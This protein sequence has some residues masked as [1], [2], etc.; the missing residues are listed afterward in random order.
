MHGLKCRSLLGKLS[1]QT[2]AHRHT[3]T[4]TSAK[5]YT[6]RHTYTRTPCGRHS[7]DV[8]V[9][10]HW[11]HR[12][13]NQPSDFIRLTGLTVRSN[14]DDHFT[15]VSHNPI[16]NESK[17][18]TLPKIGHT[19]IGSCRTKAQAPRIIAHSSLI[20]WTVGLQNPFNCCT[21]AIR[22]Q[23]KCVWQIEFVFK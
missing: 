13:S 22:T 21:A 10:T 15:C 8:G 12:S 4:S 19:R 7:W 20:G 16:L 17:N 18:A 1:V 23:F 11:C 3:S 5:V 6:L 2:C 14:K 9:G